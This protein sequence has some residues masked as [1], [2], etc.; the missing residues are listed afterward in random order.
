MNKYLK[1]FT[2]P[3]Q[4]IW[5]AVRENTVKSWRVLVVREPSRPPQRRRSNGAQPSVDFILL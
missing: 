3:Q 5:Q 4:E 1:Y 2:R